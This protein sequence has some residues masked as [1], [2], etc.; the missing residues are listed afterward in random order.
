MELEVRQQAS[1]MHDGFLHIDADSEALDGQ[2]DHH[3][4]E[5]SWM[6][7]HLG[8]L[9]KTINS[10]VELGVEKDC[11]IKELQVQVQEMENRLCRCGEMRQEEE[12]VECELHS[13]LPILESTDEELKYT[14]AE[15]SKYHTPPVVN[16]PTLQLIHPELNAFGTTS[17]PC[18][19][20]PR[21]GIGWCEEGMSL[22]ASPEENEVP[23]PI[24]ASHSKL[25]NPNQGQRA[26]HSV[27]PIHLSPT[28]FH[29]RHPYKPSG[30]LGP[31]WE[32]S[33]A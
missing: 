16:S 9:E 13:D 6:L 17:L 3:K 2:I 23:L 26:T 30:S 31:R 15:E 18:E 11:Q 4:A 20:C 28:I 19:E 12:E 5:R 25:V 32:P 29:L 27:G 7:D 33:I 21:L 8:S 22:V 24:R 10:L 1:H 14:N